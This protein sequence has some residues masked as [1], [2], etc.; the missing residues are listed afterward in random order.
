MLDARIELEAPVTIECDSAVDS[1][2]SE[3]ET[4][5]NDEMDPVVAKIVDGWISDAFGNSVTGIATAVE[6]DATSS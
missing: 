3:S 4:I 1:F 5:V 2:F 6:T